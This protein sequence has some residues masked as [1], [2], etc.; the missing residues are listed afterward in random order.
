MS[1][2]YQQR[3]KDTESKRQRETEKESDRRQIISEM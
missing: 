2:R 3:P 1:E